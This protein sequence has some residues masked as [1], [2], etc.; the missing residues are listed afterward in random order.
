MIVGEEEIVVTIDKDGNVS[1][2]VTG[3]KGSSCDQLT[4]ELVKMLGGEVIEYQPTDEYY[5][6]SEATSQNQELGY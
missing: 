3:V 1:M 6:T 5:E 4:E 2:K